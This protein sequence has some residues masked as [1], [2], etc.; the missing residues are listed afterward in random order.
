MFMCM[1]MYMHIIDV[2]VY[3]QHLIFHAEGAHSSTFGLG[4]APGP[5]L[6]PLQFPEMASTEGQ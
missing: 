2:H 1:Y 6:G 3:L 4:R 5:E